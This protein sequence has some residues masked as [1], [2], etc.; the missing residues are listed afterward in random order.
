MHSFVESYPLAVDQNLFSKLP[1]ALTNLN[2]L[3]SRHSVFCNLLNF[4]LTFFLE[5][6]PLQE[7]HKRVDI[8]TVLKGYF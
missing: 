4:R 5:L 6:R 7:S 1:G 8:K 2:C 3:Y